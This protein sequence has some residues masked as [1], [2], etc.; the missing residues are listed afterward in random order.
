MKDLLWPGKAPV[1]PLA[2]LAEGETV[3]S[4]DLPLPEETEHW[5]MVFGWTAPLSLKV[6]AL[7]RG[8]GVVVTLLFKT[9]AC[10]PCARCLATTPLAIKGK[11]RYFYSLRGHDHDQEDFDEDQVIP[12]ERSQREI[13]LSDP[14]W[15]SLI[16]ALP[17][18]VLCDE[19]C[20]GLCPQCGADLNSGPCRC[21]AT[22][23][24]PR[25]EALKD[26][27]GLRDDEDAPKG[28]N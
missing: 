18:A 23:A 9:E 19:A 17:A 25:L 4:W 13:D 2:D 11:V 12:L 15:E 5:G 20:R 10:A 22:P 28:G 6:Q 24:D 27:E 26:I 7:R 8:E 16:L 21:S 14:L 3:F 1:V